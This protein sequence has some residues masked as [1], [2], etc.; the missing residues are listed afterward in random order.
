MIPMPAKAVMSNGPRDAAMAL[1]CTAAEDEPIHA[2]TAE[3]YAL[4]R[5]FTFLVYSGSEA[6]MSEVLSVPWKLEL[7]VV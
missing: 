6:R 1:G 4:T 7:G 3:L 2:V 5:S